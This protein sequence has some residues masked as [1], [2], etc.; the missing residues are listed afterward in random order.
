VCVLILIFRNIS[1]STGRLPL[2]IGNLTELEIIN[3]SRGDFSAGPVPDSIRACSHLKSFTLFKCKFQAEFP[4]GL[5][6][7][8]SLGISHVNRLEL[9]EMTDNKIT[10]SIPNW[11][12][13]LVELTLLK[14][15]HNQIIG[16]I[17][18]CIGRLINLSIINLSDNYL[19]GK[20]PVGLCDLVNLEFLEIED[21]KIEG[22]IFNPNH[23]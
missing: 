10:G 6:G 7:L 19:S 22:I 5:E 21:N 3:I 12:C 11:V 9:I 4:S 20:L 2:E 23:L 17:P 13:E 18:E 8:K 14:M 16:T 15:E 1:Y